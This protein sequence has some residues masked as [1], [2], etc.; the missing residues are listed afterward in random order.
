[1]RRDIESVALKTTTVIVT[2][3]MMITLTNEGNDICG[4]FAG[5]KFFKRS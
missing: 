1:M 2:M 4:L 5:F 3:I